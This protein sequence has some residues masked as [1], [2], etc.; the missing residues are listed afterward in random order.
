ML[1]F[2]IDKWW[3]LKVVY[4]LVHSLDQI[5]ISNDRMSIEV[6]VLRLKVF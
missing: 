3:F 5:S 2:Q 1:S 6:N 4:G